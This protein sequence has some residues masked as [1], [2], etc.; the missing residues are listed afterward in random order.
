MALKCVQRKLCSALRILYNVF[1]IIFVLA[2]TPLCALSLFLYF[3]YIIK[4]TSQTSTYSHTARNVRERKSKE[5]YCTFAQNSNS[6]VLPILKTR[7]SQ[8]LPHFHRLVHRI[9]KQKQQTKE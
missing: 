8:S 6:D 2:V 9:L 1:K 4:F 3:R 5:K 7:R